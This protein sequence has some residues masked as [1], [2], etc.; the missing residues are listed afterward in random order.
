MPHRNCP[1]VQPT[2]ARISWEE[3]PFQ[4]RVQYVDW[5]MKRIIKEDEEG[6][7]LS[8]PA[9]GLDESQNFTVSLT[10]Y[11]KVIGVYSTTKSL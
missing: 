10:S 2:V 1:L 4:S 9:G 6:H 3:I 11:N 8:Y 7:R 5:E